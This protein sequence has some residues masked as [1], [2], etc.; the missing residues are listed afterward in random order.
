[1]PPTLIYLLI[2]YYFCLAHFQHELLLMSPSCPCRQGYHGMFP[3]I[4]VEQDEQDHCQGWGYRTSRTG[5]ES[6]QVETGC[7]ECRG[8]RAVVKQAVG[9]RSIVD[10][11]NCCYTAESCDAGKM[12]HIKCNATKRPDAQASKGH[13]A[14][15]QQNH[16]TAKRCTILSV[17]QAIRFQCDKVSEGPRCCGVNLKR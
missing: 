12:R 4:D 2:R 16:V 7:E 10:F 11:R 14:I 15:I 17:R 3:H 5:D 9:S 1:M 13:S 6:E 8:P